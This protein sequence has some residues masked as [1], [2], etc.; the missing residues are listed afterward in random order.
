[1]KITK[2][3]EASPHLCTQ[4]ASGRR[5]RAKRLARITPDPELHGSKGSGGRCKNGDRPG[6]S[7]DRA[8]G[9]EPVTLTPSIP[10][11]TGYFGGY[12]WLESLDIAAFRV[13]HVGVPTL[14]DFGYLCDRE[15]GTSSLGPSRNPVDLTAVVTSQER[16][17]FREGV[18]LAYLGQG[19]SGPSSG[20][21]Q[22]DDLRGRAEL[23]CGA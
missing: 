20:V 14:C 4:T 10:A 12:N 22:F 8:S 21:R 17:C 6:E 15:A 3:G 5:E 9:I 23:G 18:R 7:D 19:G 2:G 11:N 13:V 1:M 16:I